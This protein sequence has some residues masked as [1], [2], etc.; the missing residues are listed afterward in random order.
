MGESKQESF[1][2]TGYMSD[3]P[4]REASEKPAE[5]LENAAEVAETVAEGEE[6]NCK[7]GCG[8]STITDSGKHHYSCESSL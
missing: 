1:S 4:A 5:V 8:V 6:S 3:T 7:P 2:A